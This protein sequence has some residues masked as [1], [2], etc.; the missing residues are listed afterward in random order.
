MRNSNGYRVS[1]SASGTWS[2]STRHSYNRRSI[3]EQQLDATSNISSRRD[4][5]SIDSRYD[6]SA[7]S[8]DSEIKRARNAAF[9][10]VEDCDSDLR[11]RLAKCSNHFASAIF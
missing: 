6:L 7:R 9:R 2:N 1:H 11:M 5:V 4:G 10:I 8:G 3:F